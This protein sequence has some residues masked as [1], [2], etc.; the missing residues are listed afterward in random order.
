MQALEPHRTEGSTG[1]I[2]RVGEETSLV[3]FVTAA[4]IASTLAV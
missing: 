1:R 2:V 3:R 4:R